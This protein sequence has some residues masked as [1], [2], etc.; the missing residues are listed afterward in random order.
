MRMA[1]RALSGTLARSL[2]RASVAALACCAIDARAD[3]LPPPQPLK[4][5]LGQE[6][7]T[8]H[9]GTYCQYKWCP[10]VAVCPAG[11]ACVA[12]SETHCDP[13]GQPCWT[14]NVS[15]C[16]KADRPLPAPRC[17]PRTTADR[18]RTQAVFAQ[19]GAQEAGKSLVAGLGRELVVCYGDVREGV[20]QADGA[21]VLQRDRPVPANA[22]RL[23][24]LLHHLVHGLPFDESAV[25]GGRA[26]SEVVKAGG[27]LER[28]AHKL[29]SELRRAFRLSPLPFEDLSQDYR[30]RCQALRPEAPGQAPK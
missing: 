16:A 18:K 4:C 20:L 23:G 3:V 7:Q 1:T 6:V 19:L 30:K 15:R 8:D 28:T 24:H 21:V 17:P 14:G 25:R 2:F 11:M 27:E 5:G 29:E 12:R 13:R 9:S 10:S 22:A 26:C